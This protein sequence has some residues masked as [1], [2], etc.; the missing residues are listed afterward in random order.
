MLGNALVQ[1]TDERLAVDTGAGDV[2]PVNLPIEAAEPLYVIQ[3]ER[4][5]DGAGHGIVLPELRQPDQ[6][7]RL[8]P[9]GA[10]DVVRLAD[11]EVVPI[12]TVDVHHELVRRLGRYALDE[13]QAADL[14]V[15]PVER[16][17]RRTGCLHWIPVRVERDDHSALEA[18]LGDL[19]A[20][21]G[22][23]RLDQPFVDWHINEGDF[24]E[25]DAGTNLGVEAGIRVLD[26]G[27]EGLGQTVGQHERRHDEA[28]AHQHG[29]RCEEKSQLAGGKVAEG[30]TKDLA[31]DGY[32]SSAL[33]RS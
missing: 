7:E 23:D 9:R 11:D 22:G 8:R 1:P 32:S 5:E 21:D 18:G 20:V 4:H 19:D 25:V 28:D 29:E 3:R 26:D 12:G 33:I 15:G 10:D 30:E 14:G 31:H 24:L 27:V 17:D 2:D 13:R 6:L 16:Q